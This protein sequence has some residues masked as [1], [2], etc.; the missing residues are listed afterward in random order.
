MKTEH[1]LCKSLDIGLVLISKVIRK[2]VNA[3]LE[4]IGLPAGVSPQAMAS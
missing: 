4:D 2:P 3:K 1:V